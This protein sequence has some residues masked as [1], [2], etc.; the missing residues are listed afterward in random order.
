PQHGACSCGGVQPHDDPH[1]SACSCEDAHAHD[2]CACGHAHGIAPE[3]STIRRDIVLIFV[4]V[5]LVVLAHFVKTAP[6]LAGGA[7]WAA[8]ALYLI[9]YGLVGRKVLYSAFRNILRGKIFDENFLMTVATFGAF[10]IGDFAEAV[11]VMIFYNIGE[12]LQ[13]IAVAKSR[14]NIATLMDIRPDFA[15]LVTG[16]TERE[17]APED[18]RVG[19]VILIRPGE[20]VPLDCVVLSGEG[21]V[22]AS[23]LTGESMPVSAAPGSALSNGSVNMNGVLTCKV[24]SVFADSTVQKILNLVSDASGKKADAE[25]FIT[26]FSRIYTPIVMG[27]AVL[28]ALVP[29]LFYG[30]D[31]FSQWFY[32]GLIFLVVSCPCALVVSI[33]VSFLGGIGGAARSGVLVKG[34]D[35]ID[36]LAQPKLV[37]FDKTGTLTRGKFAV[38]HVLPAAGAQ[39]DPAA[40]LAAVALC[41][42]SSNH[43]IALSVRAYCGAQDSG[44]ALDSYEEKAGCGVLAASGGVTYAAGNAKL[45]T[46]VGAVVPDKALA[47]AD[48]A[49]GTVLHVARDK[50][51]L[52]T[53]LI[54]DSIK[55]G[56]RE[57]VAH[58]HALGVEQCCML[59]GDN[60]NVARSVAEAVG[61]DSYK[62]GLLPNEKV[63]AFEALS[64]GVSGV[65]LYTGDGIND[66]PLLAR[67]DIGIAMG[68]VGSDAAIE[69]ADVVLMTDE[70]DKIASAILVARRTRRIVMQNI[71]FALGVKIIIMAV[72]ALGFAPMWLAIFGDV[73][74]ALLAVA[75]AARAVRAVK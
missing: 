48:T 60:E 13:D 8:L 65:S 4:A 46:L 43:P 15:R 58:L 66:A 28:I 27:L 25:K 59:T 6:A 21:A 29:P 49:I 40:L 22:D 75:N 73:G 32:R 9:A 18:A 17:I 57:A 2:G 64:Q 42:R 7:F 50:T 53:L 63:A 31:T 1:H 34:G 55:P 39:A 44:A 56:V 47:A 5:A 72:A 30:F 41:E 69:A 70:V 24:T 61:L 67:A 26:R 35:V 14:A 45:M 10:A 11:A 16:D 12:T 23:A 52:G 33:P 68:G 20:R 54:A 37:V 36:R 62:A 74:V 3:K 71:I 51:Y 38:S 19:D